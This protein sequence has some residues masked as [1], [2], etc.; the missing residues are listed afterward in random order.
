MLT[1]RESGANLHIREIVVHSMLLFIKHI[2]IRPKAEAEFF[3]S[4]IV[5]QSTHSLLNKPAKHLFIRAF[6]LEKSEKQKQR[7]NSFR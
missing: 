7:E 2:K 5:I 4:F 1:L 3:T 6:V